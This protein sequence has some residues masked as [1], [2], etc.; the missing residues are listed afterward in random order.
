MLVG[1]PQQLNPVILLSE[2]D[3]NTLKRKYKVSE[4]Y[5][6]LK[7]SI[8]KTFLSCDSVNDEVLL[9]T[10]YRC[11]PKIIGF[12]NQ[13]YYNN[14]LQIESKS[15][16][17]PLIFIDIPNNYSSEKNVAPMEVNE[18]IAFI[19]NNRKGNIGIITPFVR[20]KEEIEERLRRSG[21]DDVDCGTVHAFQGDEKDI[22]IFSLGLSNNTR[23]ETYNWLK[24]NKELINVATSRAKQKLVI[25]GSQKELDRL[26]H[27]NDRD[28]I[29][30][31]VQYVNKNG[32]YEV[33]KRHANSRA[34]GIKPY[35]SKTEE[36]FLVTL[37]HALD[38]AFDD[39][40]KYVIHKEV[41]ISQVFVNN[42]SWSDF[43]YKGRFDFV[44]YQKQGKT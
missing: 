33:T 36:T 16:E 3:N 5:D 28:D 7:N 41:A 13:K 22:I 24:N 12:N 4:E 39:G 40:S 2:A 8:Y 11:D 17:K 32:D 9:R 37:N 1:D 23:E 31:L 20:Q 25:I 10:H 29:Y 19:Q 38:N 34:L 42:S 18:T 6:Y 43:F 15:N 30:E 26:H 44:V 21:I 35:S 27:L 14:K